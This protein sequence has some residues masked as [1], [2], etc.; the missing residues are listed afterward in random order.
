MLL[1]RSRTTKMS[2]S[3]RKKGEMIAKKICHYDLNRF[4]DVK[5]EVGMIII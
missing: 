3:D 4:V 5:H 1:F 2:T